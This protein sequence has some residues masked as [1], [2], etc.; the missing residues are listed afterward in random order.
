MSR[1]LFLH[2]LGIT[3][4]ITALGFNFGCAKAYAKTSDNTT[5]NKASEIEKLKKQIP[6]IKFKIEDGV[7]K[8]SPLNADT[9]SPF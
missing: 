9:W 1:K 7:A 3:A 6:N 5:Y 2:K 8:W 4:A